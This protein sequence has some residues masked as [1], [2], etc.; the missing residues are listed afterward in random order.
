[1]LLVAATGTASRSLQ[2][3]AA[4]VTLVVPST[5]P[6]LAQA[7]NAGESPHYAADLAS[8]RYSSLDQIHAGNVG[9]LEIIWRGT[10]ERFR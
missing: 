9:A 7:R 3:F 6:G 8:T 4:E 2:W 1:M 10:S 5:S